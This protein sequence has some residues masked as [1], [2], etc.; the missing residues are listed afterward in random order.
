MHIRQHALM[1]VNMLL[2][3][4]RPLRYLELLKKMFG[5]WIAH[6]GSTS[7]EFCMLYLLYK[8]S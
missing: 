8:L 4:L 3:Y 5:S 7:L 6:K 1:V 2:P